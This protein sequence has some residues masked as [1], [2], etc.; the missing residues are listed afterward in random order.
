[1]AHGPCGEQFKAAFSCFVYSKDEPKGVDCIEHFKTMQ[2]CFR[3][4]P[5]IYGSELEEDEVS[6]S[7]EGQDKPIAPEPSPAA[8]ESES[9]PMPSLSN[10]ESPHGRGEKVSDHT[11]ASPDPEHVRAGK[12]ERAKAATQ[13]VQ[14][15]HGPLSESEKAV[16]KAAHDAR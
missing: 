8:A 10:M 15:D 12:E 1:M 6:E 5:D 3:D 2:N 4:H 16:P 11:D 7:L 13:Q 9:A 14:Q